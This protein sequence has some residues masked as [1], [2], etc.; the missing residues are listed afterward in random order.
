LG[1][2][3][4]L[5]FTGGIGENAAPIRDRIIKLLTWVGEFKVY[6]IPTDEE[7]VIAKACQELTKPTAQEMRP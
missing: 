7:I 6:I 4:A 2:L 5:V 3:D 1:G